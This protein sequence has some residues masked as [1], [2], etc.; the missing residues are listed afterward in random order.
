MKR[1][2]WMTI[3]L[4]AVSGATAPAQSRGSYFFEN[5]LLRSKLNPAFAPK[6]DY[7]SFFGG[8]SFSV[9]MAG[10]VGLKT[11]F[12]P[13]GDIN[14]S[15]LSDAV[16]VEKFL[17]GLP[18]GDP[19]LRKRVESDLCGFGM[20]M[21]RDGYATLSLSVVDNGSFVLPGD[22]LRYAKAGSTAAQGPFGG[23]SAELA[24]YTAMAAGYSHDLSSFAEGLRAG[25]RVKLLLGLAAGRFAFDNIGMQFSPDQVSAVVRGTGAL[26][27]IVY[28]SDK[29]I[30]VSR[31]GIHSLGAAIDFGA[32]YWIPLD[33]P[34]TM[35][36]IELSASVCDLGGLRYSHGVSSLS[37]DHQFEF[38]GIDDISGDLKEG[39][40]KAID[41]LMAFS[42]IDASNGEP[43]F[44]KLSPSIHA[45]A[46]AHLWQDKANAGLLYYHSVGHSNLMAAGGFSPFEWLNLGVS[47]TFLGPASRLGFYA[48]FIPKKYVGLF[49]GTERASLSVNS[50]H[51]PVRSFTESMAFGLNILFN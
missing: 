21:G 43:F 13:E 11:F 8:G 16:P 30:S 26:S 12:F 45:G 35:S 15:F 36:G 31:P 24:G 39:F 27:G 44:Y 28:S 9:D 48:E 41:D 50:S 22:L 7:A 3:L 1:F 32:S 33:G 34:L 38:S 6:N 4:L 49:F 14:Y 51:I 23:G 20:K 46:S 18:G 29:G 37:L 2:V 17:S 19:Y 47:W 10:N 5:S 40:E 42:H 25:V